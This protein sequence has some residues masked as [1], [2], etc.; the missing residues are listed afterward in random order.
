[1]YV[2]NFCRKAKLMEEIVL[3]LMAGEKENVKVSQTTKG[4]RIR[5]S[6]W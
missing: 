4:K 6:F 2:L 3:G 1:M 5:K